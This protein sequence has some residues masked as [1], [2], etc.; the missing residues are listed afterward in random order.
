MGLAAPD[1][2]YIAKCMNIDQKQ[3]LKMFNKRLQELDLKF[4]ARDVEPFLFSSEQTARILT[5]KDYWDT[6]KMK[7][8]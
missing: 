6:Q 8:T 3:F 1:F 2:S 7:W 4:L 5:F